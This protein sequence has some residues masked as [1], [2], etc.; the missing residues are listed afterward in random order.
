MSAK[1]ITVLDMT[2]VQCSVR[3]A[4]LCHNKRTSYKADTKYVKIKKIDS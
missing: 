4:K 1:K 3:E 2:S